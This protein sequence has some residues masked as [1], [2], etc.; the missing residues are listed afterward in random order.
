M[1]LEED[2]R[3]NR[4]EE[5]LQL[6]GEVSGSQFF[7]EKDITWILFLNKTDLLREKIQTRPISMFFKEYPADSTFHP[8]P[9]S[10]IV[11]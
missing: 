9:P 4:L 7:S 6:F 1:K 11:P 5:S 10:R 8:L 3:T 2:N